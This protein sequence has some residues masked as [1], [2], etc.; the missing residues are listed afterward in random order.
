MTTVKLVLK[1]NKKNESGQMPIYLRITLNRR[2]RFVSTGI[3]ILPE[4]WDKTNQRVKKK[5]L[6]SARINALLSKKV[7]EVEAISIDFD[8]SKKN[9]TSQKIKETIIGKAKVDMIKFIEDYL[10]VILNKGKIGTYKKMKTILDKFK[11][12]TKKSEFTFDEFDLDFLKKY[13]KY[14]REKLENKPNTIHSNLKVLRKFFNDAIREEIIEPKVSPFP[15]FKIATEKTTKHYLTEDEIKKIEDLILNK[16]TTIF[17]HRNMYIF[18]CYAGGIRVSDLLQLKW[19]NFNG[20]HLNFCTNKTKEVLSIKLPTKALQILKIYLLKK[21]KKT[22]YI[23]PCLDSEKDY[24]NPKI[25]FN[26]IASNNA[27]INKN[28]KLIAQKA[29]ISK[30]I[31]FHTSR[32]TWATRALQKGMRIE[33]VSKL[34]AHSSINTT[35]IYAKIVNS[36]LDK[37]MEIFNN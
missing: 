27:Y 32:H 15:K 14:L 1:L 3:K 16:K 6:N 36:E 24:S 17:H 12:Y 13:D 4:L 35:Q 18:A 11:D 8:S 33:Y 37:A 5:Q 21:C 22:D 23:F 30:N 31:S 26:A 29:Q 25:K 19:D 7:A 28:L 10:E 34:L 9:S 20:T 2:V